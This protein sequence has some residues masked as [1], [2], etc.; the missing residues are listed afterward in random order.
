M[1]TAPPSSSA[2]TVNLRVSLNG[3]DFYPDDHSALLFTYTSTSVI[4]GLQP[5]HG[6]LSGG[7][8]VNVSGA[9]FPDMPV[10]CLFSGVPST[11]RRISPSVVTCHTPTMALSSHAVLTLSFADDSVV[12]RSMLSFRFEEN[13]V[14]TKIS[15][16]TITHGT[17]SDHI[18][19]ISGVG[20]VNYS[21]Q[22]CKVGGVLFPAVWI[23]PSTIECSISSSVSP[24]VWI[25]SLTN[26][27][28]DFVG[29]ESL[30]V[31]SQL[32]LQSV[33]PASGPV[34]G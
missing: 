22:M 26:N 2:Q 27:G 28:I 33:T 23:S 29:A 20:F 7:T 9:G 18:I 30:L 19:T 4:N 34:S 15:P 6:P 11:G 17:D 14:I 8:P 31:A 1:C 13:F 25:L 3:V 16:S 24:G 5:W 10:K 32:V 12:I 21:G